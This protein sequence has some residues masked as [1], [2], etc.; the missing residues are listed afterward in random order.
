MEKISL[1]MDDELDEQDASRLCGALREDANGTQAQ[2]WRT[3]HLIG[4]CL[5]D[6]GVSSP[7]FLRRVN[8]ALA[9]EPV[10]LAPRR[11]WGRRSLRQAVPLGAAAAVLVGLALVVFAPRDPGPVADSS[12]LQR[13]A[14]LLLDHTNEL[15]SSPMQSLPVFARV[16]YDPGAH[17]GDAA[18]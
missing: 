1:L 10:V 3:F 13:Q 4:D 6:E 12:E 15:V 11:P 14:L 8:A 17:V 2:A 5:R 9:E 7:D 16:S 18:R